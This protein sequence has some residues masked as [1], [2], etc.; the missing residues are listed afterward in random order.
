[1]KLH[2]TEKKQYKCEVCDYSTH[3]SSNL[4]QHTCMRKHT[5]DKPFKCDHCDY[6]STQSGALQRHINIMHTENVLVQLV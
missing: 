3:H 2:T 6:S 5:G 4:K 1:M